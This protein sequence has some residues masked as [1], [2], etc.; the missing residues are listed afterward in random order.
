[1]TKLSVVMSVYNGAKVLRPTMDSILA[2]T[3]SD[4]ELIAI[5]D[6]SRDDTASI[7]AEYAS[8]DP[9][10]RVLTQPN[11]GLTRALIRGCAEARADVIARHD[12]GDRS[13]PERFATQFALIEQGH[14]LVSCATRFVDPEGDTV[15]V[16]RGDGEE[17]R[18]SLLHDDM[19]KIHGITSH[20]SAMFRRDA[21]VR[22]GGY[23]AEF[24]AAQDLDLWIR[25]AP[26]GTIV[27]TDEVLF[28]AVLDPRG[29]SGVGRDAQVQLA[30]IAVELRDGGDPAVLLERAS[31]VRPARPTSRREAAGLYFIAKCLLADGNRCGRTYLLRAIRRNPLHW[32]AWLSLLLPLGKR[33]DR[34]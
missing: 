32:K 5:D 11:Q 19:T 7:L 15:Y 24:R 14:V 25:L 33:A 29:I 28:E 34:M 9:R 27:V 16:S 3:E 1:M 2:Q 26:L 23:R 22:A 13:L 17:I 20:G 6:G 31:R 4:F 10:V 30:A 21:Y 8:R 12:C 18:N